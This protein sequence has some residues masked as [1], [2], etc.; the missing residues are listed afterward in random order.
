MWPEPR[1]IIAGTSS[2]VSSKAARYGSALASRL[3]RLGLVDRPPA[4]G[5]GVVDEDVGDA[6]ARQ[7]LARRGARRRRRRRGRPASPSPCRPPPSLGRGPLEPS[8]PA[9]RGSRRRRVAAST[10][11]ISSR[12][13]SRH[14]SGSSS[15]RSDRPT[16]GSVDLCAERPAARD[17]RRRGRCSLRRLDQLEHLGLAALARTQL[18]RVGVA[19]DDPLEEL[20]AVLVGGQRRLGPAAG[21]VRA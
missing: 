17:Q 15:P 7:H 8:R 2:R 20:L 16:L 11:A 14:R 1:A 13:R 4:P 19:V 9:R 3:A 5:A 12:S 10:V 21:V 18:D 6:R